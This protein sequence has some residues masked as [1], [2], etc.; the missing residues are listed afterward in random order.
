MLAK[1]VRTEDTPE[2]TRQ[3]GSLVAMVEH[4]RLH[5]VANADHGSRD[6]LDAHKPDKDHFLVHII[7][8]GDYERYGFN[9]NADAFTKR[10]NQDYHHTFTKNAY[11]FREHQNQDPEKRI[12]EIAGSFYNDAMGRV[13]LAVWGHKKRAS[14]V[15]DRLAAGENISGSMACLVDYDVDS[16]TQKQA[17][18]RTEYEPHMKN[19]P[20]QYIPEYRKYAFVY[21][22]HP[23]FID[24]SY[25]ARP[26]DRIAHYLDYFLN[27]DEDAL[28]KAASHGGDPVL[29]GA[30]LAEAQ[31][32]KAAGH[33]M[34]C[35]DARTTQWLHR[36][37]EAEQDYARA[38]EPGADRGLTNLVKYAA[39]VAYDP[40][41]DVND[42]DL[43]ALRD[44]QPGTLFLEMAKRAT[45]LPFHSFLAYALGQPVS[46]L[47][48][49]AAC[50]MAGALLP[51]V[52]SG[53]VRPEEM[54]DLFDPH[55]HAFMCGCDPANTDNVQRLLDR[56][57]AQ[58]SVHPRHRVQRSITIRINLNTGTDESP[59]KPAYTADEV[60]EIAESSEGDAPTQKEA[61][62]LA[63]E[64][65][66][67]ARLY[68]QYKL[69]A[70]RAIEDHCSDYRLDKEALLCLVSQDHF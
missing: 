18:N 58:H 26:A 47:R 2:L 61:S 50:H 21:N 28:Q 63:R 13:E 24:Y 51:R 9:R 34:A 27:S 4:G 65:L 49:S 6:F 22:P 57:A 1:L 45:V 31:G 67:L 56:V 29:T 3:F 14:D 55:P 59:S 20:G 41:Q 42:S 8:L 40:G 11:F 5:K 53:L 30:L 64:A 33:S 60:R 17:R 52:F 62:V 16:C 66:D 68:G 46:A 37:A 43:S 23:N 54:P 35:M 69:A 38:W 39:R 44:L 15:R 7:G 36:L 32:I 25:V 19:R 70:V 12:G 48:K 10:A